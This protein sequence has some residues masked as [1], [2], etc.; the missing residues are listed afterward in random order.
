VEFTARAELRDKLER[1]RELLSHAVPSGDLGEL[2]ERA[3]DALIEK[4]ARCG[5]ASSATGASRSPA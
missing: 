3:L 4:K 5:D 1:A 2:F